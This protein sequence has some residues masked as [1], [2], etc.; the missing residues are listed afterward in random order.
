MVFIGETYSQYSFECFEPNSS[1]K[2]SEQ[3]ASS[4]MFVVNTFKRPLLRYCWAK[5]GEVSQRFFLDQVSER[6]SV[7]DV[8]D[9]I[10]R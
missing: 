4:M 6:K 1:G 3:A 2:L 8:F 10:P 5:R 7:Y 9:A